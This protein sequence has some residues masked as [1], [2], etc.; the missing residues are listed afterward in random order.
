VLYPSVA[1]SDGLQ[2]L[3]HFYAASLC[4]GSTAS[5]GL[6]SV[7]VAGLSGVL[8]FGVDEANFRDANGALADLAGFAGLPLVGLAFITPHIRLATKADVTLC[9]L[10]SLLFLEAASRGVVDSQR[11]ALKVIV[12]VTLFILPL[13]HHAVK[14]GD[15]S[16][17]FAVAVFVTSTVVIGVDRHKLF[18]GMRCENWF[19]YCI[20]ITALLIGKSVPTAAKE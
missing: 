3:M 8:R 9:T 7:G 13:V 5:L 18:L 14:A 17:A 2:A 20:G 12:N 19:H 4:P 16:L 15:A 10:F 6:V 11:E 1:V